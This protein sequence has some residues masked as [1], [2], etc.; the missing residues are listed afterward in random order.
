MSVNGIE[1]ETITLPDDPANSC[2]VFSHNAAFHHGSYGYLTTIHVDFVGRGVIRDILTADRKLVVQFAVKPD[3]QNKGG[4]AIFGARL[5]R[6]PL[7]PTIRLYARG[8]I[9]LKQ[10]WYYSE[11]IAV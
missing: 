9:G 3:A 1:V 5:G 11:S 4:L 7:D 10:G 2:G 8:N 6:Y